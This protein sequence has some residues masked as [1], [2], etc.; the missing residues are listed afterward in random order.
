MPTAANPAFEERF[1]TLPD[2]ARAL[3]RI[4]WISLAITAVLAAGALVAAR[5]TPPQYKASIVISP[6]ASDS[7]GQLGGSG[8]IAAQLGGLATLAG[9]SVG[10]DSKRVES[11]AV[12]Q[13]EAFTQR[14]IREQN[15]LP[16]LFEERW[17]SSR[18]SWKNE[19]KKKIPTLWQANAFFK[20]KVRSVT[21]ESKTGLVIVSITWKDPQLASKWANDLVRLANLDLRTRTIDEAERNIAYLNEQAA[22]TNVVEAKQVI[23]SILKNEI[24]RVMLARGS[25]EYA[26]RVLD[27]AVPPE[28]PVSP[29]PVLWLALALLCSALLCTGLA[30]ATI[31]FKSGARRTAD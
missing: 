11:L 3:W 4:K 13:S 2:L 29:D 23:Y 16:I 27:P 14:Y 26:F 30:V 10:S 19:D 18:R 17:D 6:V 9:I 7:A 24:N 1:V 25:E 31:A 20:K 22:K 5:M 8:G 28:F 12:L 21:T 15:L